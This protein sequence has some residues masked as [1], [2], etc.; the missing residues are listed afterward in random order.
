MHRY[1]VLFSYISIFAF[2]SA[3]LHAKSARIATIEWPPYTTQETKNMG[4]ASEIVQKAFNNSQTD[5]KILFFPWARALRYIK[6]G[7]IDAIFP[8]YYDKSRLS[9]CEYSD[10]ILSSPAGLLKRKDNLINKKD[11]LSGKYVFG[12]VSGYINNKTID[13]NTKIE[14]ILVSS[15]EQNLKLLIQR[16]VDFIYID[17]KVAK[18]YQEKMK[19][20]TQL[21][22]IPEYTDDKKLYV[23][24]SKKVPNYKQRVLEFNQAL[25]KQ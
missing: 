4:I 21:K 12:L 23:C 14:K 11:I 10:P 6:V 20:K 8:E 1:F 15:D 7:F 13:T 16:K 25:K 24:F 19:D 5:L 18:Y 2:S 17:K 22:F 9:F 3:K